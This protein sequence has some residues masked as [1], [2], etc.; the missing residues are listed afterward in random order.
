MGAMQHVPGHASIET[1]H[2]YARLSEEAVMRE[3]KRIRGLT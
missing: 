2:R 3:A 1:T